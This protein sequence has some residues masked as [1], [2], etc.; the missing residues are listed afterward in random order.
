[1][2]NEEIQQIYDYSKSKSEIVQ[3]L[4]IRTNQNGINIDK[5]ILKYFSKIGILTREQIS[6]KNLSNHWLEIQKRDYELNPKYCLWCGKKLPF[7]KRFLKCCNQSC[8]IS[9]TNK[10]KGSKSEEEKHKISESLK[11][12]N[13]IV[14][15]NNISERLEYIKKYYNNE[16]S[17]DDIK[18]K[19]PEIIQKCKECYKEFIPHI[20]K[21]R[22]KISGNKYCCKKCHDISLSRQFKELRRKEIESGTF[23]GWKSRNIT[24][25][26]ENFWK[27][28]LDNNNIK[29]TREYVFE[30]GNKGN[31]ERY[32]LDFYIEINNRKIDLEIDGKQHLYEDRKQSDQIRDQY[33]KSKGIEVY[34]IPWNEINTENGK[35]LM[36]EKIDN[37]IN[38]LK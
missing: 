4:N 17:F 21:N 15:N 30:Y 38:Y 25:Y 11:K 34:R 28:V 2:S 3:K 37:F 26:A 33:I 19:H 23:Q 12:Y 5:D 7:E 29:Y 27:Q 18:I 22:H 13:R 20:Q 6:K 16:I 24:S 36:K 10:Q 35:Q 9:L 14:G 1:M 32:F 31:G 8:A